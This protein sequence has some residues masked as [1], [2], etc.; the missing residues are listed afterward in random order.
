MER[1]VADWIAKNAIT[2][3][4]ANKKGAFKNPGK[5]WERR[6]SWTWPVMPEVDELDAQN[7]IAQGLKNG[8]T[9]FS[10]LLGP[11][12]E[13]KLRSYAEQMNVVRDLGLPLSVLD[14]NYG[15]ANPKKNGN[16]ATITE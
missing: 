6:M 10:K 16:Q 12:W 11:D 5:G 13:N 7:A 9:D 15:T 1:Y 14:T 4:M 2:W 8:T 3:A